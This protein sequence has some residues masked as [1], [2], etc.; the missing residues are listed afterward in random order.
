MDT[1]A[2]MIVVD[3]LDVQFDNGNFWVFFIIFKKTRHLHVKVFS[4][5][6]VIVQ[7]TSKENAASHV[8]TIFTSFSRCCVT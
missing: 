2:K 8:T 3:F 7:S 5:I 4:I 6:L 1:G